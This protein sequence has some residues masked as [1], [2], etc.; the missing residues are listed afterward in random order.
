MS[1]P[2]APLLAEVDAFD[3]PE[4]LG[5][6]EVDWTASSGLRAGHLVTGWL[7]GPGAQHEMACD[8]LAVDEA[9]PR[10]VADEATRVRAHQAWRHGQVLLVE[11]DGRVALAA[12]GTRWSAEGVLDALARLARAVG[13]SPDRYAV[14]LRIGEDR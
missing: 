12:P 7:R 14:R 9:F 5:E 2:D 3:L 4:W 6:G 8:L 11:V 10:P 13:A 1:R